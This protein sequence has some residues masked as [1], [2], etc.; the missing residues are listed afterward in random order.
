MYRKLLLNS[1]CRKC[2]ELKF[3]NYSA[4]RWCTATSS[5]FRFV[6]QQGEA[7]RYSTMKRATEARRYLRA[8][9]FMKFSSRRRRGSV[10]PAINNVSPRRHPCESGGVIDV[11]AACRT[12]YW[13]GIYVIA[14][15]RFRAN[16]RLRIY[17]T[18]FRTGSPKNSLRHV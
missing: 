12:Y 8:W 2:E 15:V 9:R 3:L 4:A 10:D 7:C 18:A 6:T 5:I 11:N 13:R 17:I 1:V 16:A 14:R